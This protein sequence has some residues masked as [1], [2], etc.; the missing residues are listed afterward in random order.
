M[1][2]KLSPYSMMPRPPGSQPQSSVKPSMTH[3]WFKSLEEDSTDVLMIISMNI[4]QMLSN[5]TDLPLL[6]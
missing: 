2:G 1:Q 3:T 4:I 6:M 5:L